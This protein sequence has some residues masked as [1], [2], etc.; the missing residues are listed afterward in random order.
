MI[1]AVEYVDGLSE[2]RGEILCCLGLTGTSWTSRGAT[3]AQ[4]ERL[5]CRHVNSVSEGCNDQTWAVTQ[6]LVTVFERGI[7]NS[8]DEVL[9][10]LKPVDLQL[11]L[12]LE[13]IGIHDFLEVEILDDITRVGVHCNHA[14]DLLAH[15]LRQIALN[16]LNEV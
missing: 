3:H 5:C 14:A 16:H 2:S 13:F 12:P 10:I 4:V 6:V 9:F 7:S 15:R 11:G 8:E 1:R